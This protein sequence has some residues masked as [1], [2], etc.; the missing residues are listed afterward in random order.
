ME[1]QNSPAKVLLHLPVIRETMPPFAGDAKD[2]A[3]LG[4][5]WRCSAPATPSGA[6]EK[7]LGQQVFAIHCALCHSVGGLRGVAG[8]SKRTG[9]PTP[10]LEC[11]GRLTTSVP[12]CHLLQAR[13]RKATPWPSI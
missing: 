7:E 8:T 4:G 1:L 3:A 10:S 9:T 2:R 11:S 12:T 5:Y 6:N 13:K